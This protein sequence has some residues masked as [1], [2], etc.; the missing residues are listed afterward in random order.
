MA[1]LRCRR[2]AA[3]IV[4]GPH[5]LVILGFADGGNL[6]VAGFLGS[7][8][9]NF[10]DVDVV[11]VTGTTATVRNAA[12]APVTVNIRHPGIVA[13]GKARLGIRL[14]YLNPDD[15]AGRL[16]GRVALTERLGA[17]TVI[18]VRLTDGS[19]LIVALAR[20]A[21]FAIGTEISLAFDPAMARLFAI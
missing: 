18:E 13:G 11:A 1:S 7:P 17:E 10:L 21:T 16:H 20:D 14:Q 8:A 19:N 4:D 3:R 6:F 12:L 5:G 2:Y 9:M 15:P